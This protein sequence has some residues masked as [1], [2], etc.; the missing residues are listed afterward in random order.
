M[1]LEGLRLGVFGKGG[2]GKSTI[3][4]LLARAMAE[5]G[6][7]PV[8]LDA[9]STNIGLA[10]ALGVAEAPGTLIEHFGGLVFNGGRVTC[11]VDDPTPL[12]GSALDLRELPGRFLGEAA[13]GIRVLVGGKMGDLGPGAG[14]DGPIAKVARDVSVRDGEEIPPLL[15]DFKAGFEDSARGVLTGLDWA[16]VVVDPTTASLHMAV[17]LEEMVRKIRDGI[18]PATAHLTDTRLADLARRQFRESRVQGVAAVLNRVPDR[19]AETYMR[20]RLQ[21]LGGPPVIGSFP[22]ERTLQGQWLRGEEVGDE[23][24]A[25]AARSILKALR[26]LGIAGEARTAGA[27]SA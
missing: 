19:E 17:H 5:M 21:E 6:Y 24:M 3:T 8:I 15:V 11:P 2:A 7:R 14:C 1:E 13:G 12:E 23:G 10:K 18:P 22:E 9:D 4:V 20:H 27:P 26:S 16:L 25:P